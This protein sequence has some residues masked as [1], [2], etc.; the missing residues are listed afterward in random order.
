MAATSSRS[1]RAFLEQPARP[2]G[3]LTYHEL[4]GFLFAIVSAP[5]LIRPSEWLPLIF[6]EH[7]AGFAT[8]EEANAILGQIMRLYNKINAAVLEERATLPGDCRVRRVAL[9]NL[10]DSAP[11]AR[12]SRGFVL[13]HQWLEELWDVDLP[14]DWD[15]EIGAVL[16]TLSFFSSR[17]LAEAFHRESASGTESLEGFAESMLRVLP[18][19][20]AE[21]AYL[22][23]SILG[24]ASAA[25][26][27]A[28]RRSHRTPRNGRC[29]CGSGKTFKKCCGR[30]RH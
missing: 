17:N 19:A 15:E 25:I 20:V 5:E 1:L 9:D 8:L 23:R 29:P 6:N 12:W 13:G 21:Y 27:Q 24:G 3:T 16:M 2:A 10:V 26:A 18:D 30:T 22:G 28:P 7:D 11:L 4:Q 14:E